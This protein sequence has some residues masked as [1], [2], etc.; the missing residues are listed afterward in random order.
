MI[1]RRHDRRAR[2]SRDLLAQRHAILRK[3]VVGD[4]ARA[5]RPRR[6]C[7]RAGRVFRHHQRRGNAHRLRGDGHRLRMIPR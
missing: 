6:L 7:L 3:P 5:A 4:D 1:E 2:F